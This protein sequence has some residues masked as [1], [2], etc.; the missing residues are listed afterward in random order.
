MKNAFGILCLLV[1]LTACN[2]WQADTPLQRYYGLQQDYHT[3]QTAA[4]SYKT[5]CTPQPAS[6]P[7]HSDVTRI[8]AISRKVQSTFDMAEAARTLGAG[9]D[10]A[11]SVAIASTTLGELETL[12]QQTSE[13]K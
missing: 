8:Q 9:A 2:A 10:F 11:A 1:L 5:A 4:L 13:V 12:L 7:C 3:T 6:H